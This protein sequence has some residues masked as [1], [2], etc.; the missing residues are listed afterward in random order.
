MADSSDQDQERKSVGRLGCVGAI[1][2]LIVIGTLPIFAC[3]LVTTGVLQFGNEQG[4][5]LNIF[6]LQ[7]PEQEGIGVQWSRSFD[8]EAICTSTSVRYFMFEGEGE[9]LDYC[10]C[11]NDPVSRPLPDGCQ[12]SE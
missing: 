1:I 8:D 4:N 11:T 5:F 12:L 7:E 3:R 9:N 6:M 10:S 2:F